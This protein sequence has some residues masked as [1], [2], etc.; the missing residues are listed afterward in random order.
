MTGKKD[1][2]GLL[3]MAGKGPLVANDSGAFIQIC[4]FE[5]IELFLHCVHK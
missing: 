5:N 2:H 4:I 1:R 3:V